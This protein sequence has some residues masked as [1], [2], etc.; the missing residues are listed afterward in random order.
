MMIPG[1]LNL[2]RDLISLS[3]LTGPIFDKELRVSSRR[4]RNYV[5][6]F[7]YLALLTV[8][9][10]LFWLEAVHYRS[11]SA[12]LIASRMARAGQTIIM[13]I[14]WFQFCATQVLAL[15]TL[16]TS[17]SDEIYHRTLGLLMTT[18]VNSFQIVMGKLF[19]KLLQLILLLA[20]SL[21]ILAIVRVFGGVPWDYVLSSLCVT[22]T[23]AIFVGSVSLFFSIFSR[24][25]YAVI[26]MATLTLG[27][28]F[29][30]LPLIT[31]MLVHPFVSERAFFSAFSYLNPYVLLFFT[32]ESM[33]SPR[34]GGWMSPAPWLLHCG[35]MLAGSIAVLLTSVVLVRKTALR[36][37]TGQL[38]ASARRASSADSD[39]AD[40]AHAAALPK[41][42]KGPCVLWKELK[43]PVFGRHKVAAATATAMG[44]VLLFIT[45][46]LCARERIL[47]EEEIHVLYVII[48]LGLGMLFTIIVPATCITS[49]K[50]SRSWPLLLATPLDSWQIV[51]GKFIG[52]L[53][54]CL[55]IWVLLFGH[56]VV[57]SLASTIHPVAVIQ[58]AILVS[59]IIVFLSSSGVYLSS[60]F[61]RTTTAVIVN[62]A[63]AGVI[64]GL[65]PLLMFLALDVADMSDDPAEAYMDTNPFFQAVVTIDATTRGGQHGYGWAGLGT[66][67]ALEATIW[68]LACMAGYMSLG[69][70]FIW[71]AKARLRR[72]V[73]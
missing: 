50:E 4:R 60:R 25:A 65:A 66:S 28:L 32:T 51:L 44:M 11:S 22:L 31:A 1:L 15:V 67:D 27:A 62:L 23:A 57:F 26:I 68:M 49:E 19:S 39:L 69:V 42:V 18:P 47:D 3:W 16:S 41:R 24:R 5:V 73:F 59:W 34:M 48:F 33:M 72:D 54:R 61:Q 35:I 37:A 12:L 43:S 53:R 29:A 21:P 2:A 20:I 64:W 45:Y 9:L 52:G 70:L 8:L 30:V 36:Q 40:Q 13:F 38:G 46:G 14:V 71:R 17:I 55:P 58:M 56:L 10:V 7:V 63:L 6:R